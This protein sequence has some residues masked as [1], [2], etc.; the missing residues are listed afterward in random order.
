M[1]HPDLAESPVTPH[2]GGSSA[3]LR[4]GCP[5]ALGHTGR[6]CNGDICVRKNG[7]F[8]FRVFPP[9]PLHRVVGG[10]KQMELTSS[11]HTSGDIRHRYSTKTKACSTRP[12]PS[13]R[14]LQGFE[15]ALK[16]SHPK[17]QIVLRKTPVDMGNRNLTGPKSHADLSNVKFNPIVGVSMPAAFRSSLRGYFFFCHPLSSSFVAKTKCIANP[18]IVLKPSCASRMAL[19]WNENMRSER[20]ENIPTATRAKQID[21][22]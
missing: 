4:K 2:P 11:F 7:A 19:T 3:R 6:P 10:K 16:A 22:H 15:R 12:R 14:A 8:G 1:F 5:P 18:F 17:C 9:L 13:I 21:M 20:R